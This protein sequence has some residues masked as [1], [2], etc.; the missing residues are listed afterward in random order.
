MPVYNGEEYL[1]ETVNSILNQTY[2]D[3]DFLI[4]ND[5]STD[6]TLELLKRME[7]TRLKVVENTENMGIVK[8]LNRGLEMISGEYIIRMDADDIARPRRI[9][10]QVKFMDQHPNIAA[11]S[12]SAVVT[13]NGKAIN[14]LTMPRGPKKVRTELLFKSPL[15]HPAS[16]IRNDVIKT[17]GITYRQEL[18]AM[19]DYGFWQELSFV[20]NID[21]ISDSLL[22]YRDNEQGISNISRKNED[23]RDRVHYILYQ[24]HFNQLGIEITDTEASLWRKWNTGTLD[25]SNR[26]DIEGFRN[27][28]I[29]LKR[30]LSTDKYDLVY[31]DKRMSVRYRMCAK[32][33][34]QTLKETLAIHERF[35]AGT[36]I[37]HPLEKIKYSLLYFLKK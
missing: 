29:K 31:F 11:S 15:I 8:T 13:R 5:G 36:F 4:I 26:D 25:L 30:R 34:K 1:Q 35:F 3:F 20:S 10:K 12:G 2:T 18:K 17:H 32:T 28:V 7:D 33:S 37:F 23:A 21:N 27:L 19:E 16:I 14:R 9:E 22:K 24:E 6:R